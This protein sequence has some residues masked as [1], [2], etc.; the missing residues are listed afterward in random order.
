MKSF[1]LL[2][3]AISSLGLSITVK[4]EDETARHRSA[5]QEINAQLASFTKVTATHK[6]EE[7]TY[8][9]TGWLKDGE[10][11]KIEAKASDTAK[12]VE[13]YYLAKEAPLFVLY[14]RNQLEDNGKLG[15][16]I[17]ERFYFSDG[18]TISKWLT[19]E[20][21]PPVFHGE[22]YASMADL[23]N[24]NSAAFIATL[25]KAKPAGKAQASATK[26]AEGIFTG[27]EQGDYFHWNMKTK[28]GEERS[29]FI[30]KPAD[31]VSKVC[32]GPEPFVG[33]PCRVTWKASTEFI[34]EA[35]QKMDIEQVLSVEWLAKN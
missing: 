17:E 22:D 13:E 21:N 35:N 2:I 25:K 4:A 15:G 18:K 16:R 24:T 7:T 9:L 28:S 26:T 6:I 14:T 30:L 32:D 11:K 27:I 8:K 33:K 29:F 3:V 31:S 10:V 12:T 34:P 1:L 19:T 20:K 5:Y 23:F